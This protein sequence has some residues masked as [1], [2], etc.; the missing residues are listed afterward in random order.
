MSRLL[1]GHCSHL[2]SSRALGDQQAGDC[3]ACGS[4]NVRKSVS[5]TGRNA[6]VLSQL[7]SSKG[8]S[9]Q[10]TADPE[11]LAEIVE[12]RVPEG[13]ARRTQKRALVL[14]ARAHGC[15]SCDCSCSHKLL[16]EEISDEFRQPIA[17]KVKTGVRTHVWRRQAS[18]PI[19]FWP[20][21][22][23]TKVAARGSPC[24]Q[25]QQVFSRLDALAG[26]KSRGVGCCGTAQHIPLP[27]IP[28]TRN[29]LKWVRDRRRL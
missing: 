6:A 17:R 1:V 9:C 16:R 28:S 11:K 5:R 8:T 26:Q 24:Q 7:R 23:E 13:V 10:P 19:A 3:A 14:V 12:R 21:Q 20:K 18:Q 4:G 29:S 2:E 22:D 27:E 15:G 25:Y